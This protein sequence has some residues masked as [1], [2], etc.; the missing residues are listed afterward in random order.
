REGYGERRAGTRHL[1]RR[2]QLLE[3]R[4]EGETGEH[5]GSVSPALVPRVL[6]PLEEPAQPRDDVRRGL[7][8]GGGHRAL[9]IGLELKPERGVLLGTCDELVERRPR[10]RQ[11][12]RRTHPALGRRRKEA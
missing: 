4:G 6:D 1:A 7:V 2:R 11:L 3:Q 12:L 8:A 5:G 10:R 9:E